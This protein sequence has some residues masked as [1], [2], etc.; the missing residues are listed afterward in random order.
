MLS[1]T[2][3]IFTIYDVIFR[4]RL[5]DFFAIDGLS[6]VGTAKGILLIRE[7]HNSVHGR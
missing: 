2:S 4:N 5:T 7:R 1:G 6:F 3:I